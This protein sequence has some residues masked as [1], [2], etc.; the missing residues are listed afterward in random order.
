[1]SEARED[2]TRPESRQMLGQATRYMAVGLEM[3]VAVALGILAGRYADDKLGTEPYLLMV[4][5]VLGLGAAGKAIWDAAK[6]AKRDITGDN[7]TP[8]T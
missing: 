7:D 1:M 2:S 3:G 8:P 6:R 5:I 4:G